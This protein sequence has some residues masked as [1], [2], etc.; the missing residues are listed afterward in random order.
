[1]QS[2]RP[3]STTL[4]NT[5][6]NPNL[7][8]IEEVSF[9]PQYL[10]HQETIFTIGN[11]YIATRGA[12]EEGYHTERR[13]TFAHG[14]FDAARNYNT[15]LVNMP[16]WLPL[17]VCLDRERF[18]LERGTLEKY[19]RTLDLRN[20]L[21]SRTV[22]WQSPN[23]RC[24]TMVFERF[25]SL[26]DPH[27]LYLRCHVIPEFAGPVEF[28]AAL[29][30][31]SD[32]LG[33]V[34][35]RWIDQGERDGV[36]YLRTRTR[37]SQIDIAYAMRVE[38]HGGRETKH[39]F[40]DVDD[41]PSVCIQVDARPG[42]EIVFDKQ[43]S[44]F[45]SR[46][47][48]AEHVVST[49]VH[50]SNA[51]PHWQE[52]L[53]QNNTAWA[54]EWKRSDVELE[55]DDE[56]Q[57]AMR[58]NLFQ[59]LIV[60]PRHDSRVNIGAKTLSGFGY[61]GHTFWDTEIFML[62]FFT[63][64]APPVARNLLDY[65]YARLDAARAKARANGCEGAQFPWESADTGE[66]VTPPWY[67]DPS[68]RTKL[69]RIWT[70]DIEIHI[71]AD[72]AYAVRQY[73]QVTGDDEWFIDR[74]A[75]VILDTGKFYASRAEWD[76][77]RQRY[78]YNDVIGPDEYHDHVNNNAYTNKMAQWNLQT[79]LEVLEW[80]RAEAP[81]KAEE[82]TQRLDLSPERLALWRDVIEKIY[83]PITP[84]GVIEQFDGYF[85]LKPVFMAALE[86]R[87]MSTQQLFGYEGSQERQAIKQPDVLM[88]LYLLRDQFDPE[89]IRINY[90]FYAPRTD[91]TYGSSLGPA[92]SSIIACW[93][94][95][96][97]EAYEH[98]KRAEFA[99]LCD[100]R[101]NAGD[102]IH[103][104]SAGGA[105]QAVVFGFA[106][107]RLTPEGCTT[108]ACLPDGWSRLAFRF[109]RYGEEQQV[110]VNRE[111]QD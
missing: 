27:A 82:L 47:V 55:G 9:D 21:L 56:S 53:E 49:A 6:I 38:T 17:S 20:G 62:P 68:N 24:A 52:A 97:G 104:A 85:K 111:R 33:V 59:L 101:G 14:V 5:S 94:G 60:A 57:R 34:H 8:T 100:V 15:E 91:H 79:A 98:F 28:R 72:V 83:F 69:I 89:I 19:R 110:N 65:R 78:E 51:A 22:L 88:L 84:S 11:G 25:V 50:H 35:L 39:D 106:G 32:N 67:P 107:L 44:V 86:P 103:G 87:D 76:P 109:F 13:A 92:I 80:L 2:F 48:P 61:H 10:H 31:H 90:E 1:M 81:A 95:K 7:W 77:D 71:S 4:T 40:W 43:V 70:G 37:Q 73:W 54:N 42:E 96:N 99:D 45:T 102:G 64:T 105:W 3:R 29:D 12:F 63:Y 74:G 30:G 58:F 18:S 41:R 36:V 93:I 26:A 66:E 46:D 75:E 108:H 23:G 16:D